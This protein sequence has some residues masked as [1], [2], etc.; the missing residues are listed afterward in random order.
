MQC[1]D[2]KK[3]PIKEGAGRRERQ[4]KKGELG[5]PQGGQGKGSKML[6]VFNKSSIKMIACYLSIEILC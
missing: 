3:L 5:R 1:W 2:K 6:N 4:G